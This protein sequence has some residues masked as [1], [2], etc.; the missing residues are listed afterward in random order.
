MTVPTGRP[1][2]PNVD[3]ALEALGS[4]RALPSA[5]YTDADLFAREQDRVLRRSWHYVG[6]SEQ[7]AEPGD[8]LVCQV[9]GAPLV[10]VRRPD[11]D[12]AGFLNICRHRAHQVVLADQRRNSLQCHYHGWTYGLDGSLLNAPRCD[13]EPGFDPSP[14][15]L[16]PVQVAVWGA[17]VWANVDPTAPSFEEWIGGLPELVA[18]HGVDVDV[19]RL[20]FEKE[21]RIRANWKVFLDNAIECYHCPTC[22]PELSRVL[23]MDPALQEHVIGGRYWTTHTMQLRPV[24]LGSPPG[25]PVPDGPPQMYHFHWIFP[26][27][28]FQYA[29]LGFDI[30]SIDVLGVDEIRFR[31]VTFVPRDTS[32]ADVEALQERYR[33]DPTVDQDVAICE[34]VQA[35]HATGL[36]P[37]GQLLPHTEE[38]LLHYQRVD[39]EMV[40]AP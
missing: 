11:G 1:L 14:L 40:A 38:L 5:W 37:P 17:T 4:G 28:Y 36:A 12:V 34:R 35:A 13:R 20:A 21:W 10:L 3:A 7:L 9:A 23:E 31:S 25:T 19:H 15:G 32:E 29:R 16:L 18:S 8:Q 30:G 22:H 27:T 24:P 2:D 26:T 39:V 6:H 33:V